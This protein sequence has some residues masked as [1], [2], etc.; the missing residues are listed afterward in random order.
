MRRGETGERIEEIKG[1]EGR[2]RVCLFINASVP[3]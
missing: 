2:A 1:A 3:I